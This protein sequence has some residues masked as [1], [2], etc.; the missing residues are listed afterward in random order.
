TSG[1]D[2][3]QTRN[4]LEPGLEADGPALL[5]GRSAQPQGPSLESGRAGPRVPG[6]RQLARGPV[7][8]GSGARVSKRGAAPPPPPRT[9]RAM[10]VRARMR[11]STAGWVEN[12]LSMRA[13]ERGLA[14]YIWAMAGARSAASLG[15]R[16][17]MPEIFW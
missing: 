15:M 4:G 7:G 11:F 10:S 16:W 14:I 3:A 9:C 6:V 2:R 12:R 8:A 1:Q 17:A 13:P 5:F